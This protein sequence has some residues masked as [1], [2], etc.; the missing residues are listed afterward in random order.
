MSIACREVAPHWLPGVP[1]GIRAGLLAAAR[2]VR[3][4]GCAREAGPG[5]P[6]T[7]HRVARWARRRL[8]LVALCDQYSIH[9]LGFGLT[10]RLLGAG[11]WALMEMQ[12]GCHRLEPAGQRVAVARQSRA[13]GT[14]GKIPVPPEMKSPG[15]LPTDA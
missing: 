2:R 3:T 7:A 9:S 4:E 5:G 10:E 11:R 14:R 12:W 13:M 8:P 15:S 1:R 6:L